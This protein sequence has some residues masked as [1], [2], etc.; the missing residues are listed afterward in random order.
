VN[1]K[2]IKIEHDGHVKI[3]AGISFKLILPQGASQKD[4]TGEEPAPP[5]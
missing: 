2:K 1:W 3:Y 4:S 5:T